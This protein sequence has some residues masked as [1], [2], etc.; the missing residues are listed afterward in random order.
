MGELVFFGI[1]ALVVIGIGV[2]YLR[3]LSRWRD[4]SLDSQEM[5]A[6]AFMWS[7][8]SGSGGWGA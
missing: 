4:P 8:R 1:G 2:F 3:R 7:Q 6:E 5:Q